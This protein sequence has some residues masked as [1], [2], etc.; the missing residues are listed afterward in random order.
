MRGLGF[1]GILFSFSLAFANIELNSGLIYSPDT[2]RV[3]DAEGRSIDVVLETGLRAQDFKVVELTVREGKHLLL[4]H[5]SYSFFLFQKTNADI[6]WTPL[7]TASNEFAKTHRQNISR[8]K[9][10]YSEKFGAY[11]LTSFSEVPGANSSFFFLENKS[12]E[13]KDSAR[14]SDA[15]RAWISFHINTTPLETYLNEKVGDLALRA[16]ATKMEDVLKPTAGESTALTVIPTADATAEST[17]GKPE[18]P[19]IPVMNE[20]GERT[21]GWTL[22]ESFTSDYLEDVKNDTYEQIDELRAIEDRILKNFL[23]V[24]GGSVKLLAP[25][26]VGKSVLMRR[27]AYRLRVGD[28]PVSLK[29]F[30]VRYFS[31]ASLEAGSKFVGTIEARMNAMIEVSKRVPLLWFVDE[32]HAL[33]GAGV[34]EGRPTNIL[35]SLKPSLAAGTV[36]WLAASTPN[37][38]AAAF[39]TDEAMDRRFVRVD[40]TVP[41]RELLLKILNKWL[42]KYDKAPL[43]EALLEKIIFYSN[44]FGVEGAQPSKATLLLNEV[45]A[46]AEFKDQKSPIT[47]ENIQEAAQELYNVNPSEMEVDKIAERFSVLQNK[48]Q[49]IIGQDAAKNAILS[50]TVQIMAGMHDRTKPRY[51]FMLT[52][53]KGLGKTEIVKLFAKAMNLPEGRIVMSEFASPHEIESFKARIAQ[54]VRIHPMTVLSFD[55]F[56]KAHPKVQQALLGILESESFTYTLREGGVIRSA[57]V[58]IKNTSVFVL[59]NAG[60]SYLASRQ[61]AEPKAPKIGFALPGVQAEQTDTR[62][63]FYEWEFRQAIVAD[64]VDSYVL[65]RMDSVIPFLY[66]SPQQFAQIVYMHTQKIIDGINKNSV[67]Q[68]AFHNLKQFAVDFTGRNFYP[69][70][71]ARDVLR[72]LNQYIRQTLAS[73]ALNNPGEAVKIGWHEGNLVIMEEAPVAETEPTAPPQTLSCKELF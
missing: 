66:F 62:P 49:E 19:T 11:V 14:M 67:T 28:V 24:E 3:I 68:F 15:I 6:G 53:D 63:P 59:T 55:E 38:W 65:D 50:Q 36:K 58:Q 45:Y 51:R 18:I 20:R 32:A 26:G 48:L 34:S 22:V 1:F 9:I 10:N 4:I 21:D 37:E 16:I 54:L 69:Q 29:K 8:I 46:N 42:V 41:D 72:T 43:T 47:V 64:G 31:A 39:A 40:L 12:L 7:K 73:I 13:A 27:I 2:G 5:A 33:V 71:S 60:A 23:K 44:E 61:L 17:T 30:R 25:A 35:Q 56:E 57:T 70:A 52:G